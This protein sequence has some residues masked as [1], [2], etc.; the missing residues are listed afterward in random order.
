MSRREPASL[1]IYDRLA[2]TP[3]TLRAQLA[4]GR[5]RRELTALLG[6]AEYQQLA[7]L[8]RTAARTRI[9]HEPIVYVIPG[10]LG[11]QLSQP[12]RS[13]WP[14]DLLWVDPAD[15]MSGRLQELALPQHA[16]LKTAGAIA[17]S[18]L[19]LQLRLQAAG[20]DARLY[21]YDWRWGLPEL[22]AELAALLRSE[23]PR[24]IALI[25]HSMGGLVARAALASP[26]LEHVRTLISLGTPHGGSF[27]AVQA[28][29]GTYPVVRRLA[30]LDQLHDAE[31]LTS[32]VFSSFASLYQML[33]HAGALTEL[34]L[35][36]PASW[37]TTGLKPDAALLHAAR[38]A[39]RLLAPADERLICV[40][41]IRQRTVTS[42]RMGAGEFQYVVSSAG[43]GTVPVAAATLGDAPRYYVHCEH[44]EL[45]RSERIAR[46]LAQL[47]LRGRTDLLASRWR[48]AQERPVLVS[49]TALRAVGATK[50]NWLALTPAARRAYLNRLSAAPAAYAGRSHHVR[51]SARPKD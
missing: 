2:R 27:A 23:H 45:P 1:S 51:R 35:Y 18:Y 14:A 11:T 12:R 46:A 33:P 47:L 34:D 41:G 38:T 24:P 25:G 19:P 13:P 30:A 15:I 36:E 4:K 8:A 3:E 10:I 16:G 49:D 20:F 21:E 31:T 43:D 44:S 26:G 7:R 6:A 22:G 9:Q 5:P 37:P 39:G 29:R 48:Q 17:Y 40:C 32:E 50:I 28:L 42:L